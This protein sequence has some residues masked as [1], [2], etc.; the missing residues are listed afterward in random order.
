MEWST[1]EQ[2]NGLTDRQV[3]GQGKFLL[4]EGEERVLGR[5]VDL[6]AGKEGAVRPEAAARTDMF[7]QRKQFLISVVLLW[8]VHSAAS[9]LLL[10]PLPGVR[11]GCRGRPVL[12]AAPGTCNTTAAPVV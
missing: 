7:Q 11:T 9:T 4:E 1:F 2:S 6:Q 5:P 3:R 10:S 8:A 12:Q